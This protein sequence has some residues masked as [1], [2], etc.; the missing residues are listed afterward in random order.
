MS[1]GG[2][3]AMVEASEVFSEKKCEEGSRIGPNM[4]NLGP[5]KQK[6]TASTTLK[7]KSG[8]NTGGER[9]QREEKNWPQILKFWHRQPH[10]REKKGGYVLGG[11]YEK[12][13]I[14]KIFLKATIQAD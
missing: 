1:E 6:K 8:K 9:G 7:K 12:K 3:G 13:D 2:H 11:N 5:I 10:E 4:K 14:N